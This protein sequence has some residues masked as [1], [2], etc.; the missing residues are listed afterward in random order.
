MQNL[1]ALSK[2]NQTPS[3]HKKKLSAMSRDI[4]DYLKGHD[5]NHEQDPTLVTDLQYER[6]K[7]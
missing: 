3:F 4:F 2:R 1:K 5:K 7:R 6:E